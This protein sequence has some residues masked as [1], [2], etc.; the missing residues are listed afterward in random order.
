VPE[1]PELLIPGREREVIEW[2]FHRAARDWRATFTGADID[3]YVRVFSRPGS[4]RGM[5]G[6]TG[7]YP[8]TPSVLQG[9]GHYLP[10]E[11]PQA[12]A[13]LVTAF[14]DSLASVSL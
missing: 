5:L 14:G 13:A 2:F 3:E 10:E 4:L 7:R 9:V 11:D 1:L 12:V 6:Y 8:R